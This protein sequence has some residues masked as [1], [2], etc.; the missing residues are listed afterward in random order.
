[1]KEEITRNYL[2]ITSIELLKE[3]KKPYD[4]LYLNKVSKNDFQLNKFLYKQVESNW[5][6]NK[7]NII[8]TKKP[9]RMNRFLVL[10]VITQQFLG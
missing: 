10:I 8:D 9:I 7:A 3:V 2:E 5:G 6:T 4:N 1:M